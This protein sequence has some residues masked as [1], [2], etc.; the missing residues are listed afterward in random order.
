MTKPA[1]GGPTDGQMSA[2][3]FV[4]KLMAEKR[5]SPE[6]PLRESMIR[7][8]CILDG[9]SDGETNQTLKA[10]MHSYGCVEVPK[11]DNTERAFYLITS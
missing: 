6:K 9:Y 11:G 2:R 10:D 8:H 3:R 4:A 1:T 7:Y 5:P